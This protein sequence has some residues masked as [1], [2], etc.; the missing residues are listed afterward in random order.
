MARE[1]TFL[2]AEWT[3]RFKASYAR[4]TAERQRQCDAAVM[5]VIKRQ[6]TPGLRIKPLQPDKHYRE[7]RVNDGDPLIFLE[8]GETV[9][10]IDVVPHDQISRY[11]RAPRRKA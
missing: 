2:R 9:T 4:L 6:P 8:E 5:Q 7:A 11:G 1:Q 3:D 10:F